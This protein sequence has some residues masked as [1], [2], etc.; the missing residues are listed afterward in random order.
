VVG[1]NNLKFSFVPLLSVL[2][3]ALANARETLRRKGIAI[4]LLN[5]AFG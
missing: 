4:Y 1:E 5:F 3:L 2:Y